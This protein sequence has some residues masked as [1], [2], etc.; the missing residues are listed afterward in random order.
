MTST[1]IAAILSNVLEVVAVYVIRLERND[2]S[3]LTR[4]AFNSHEPSPTLH[5]HFYYYIHCY[6]M[7]VAYKD[8][9]EWVSDAMRDDKLPIP[10]PDY[11]S[12]FSPGTQ[13]LTD[14]ETQ[15]PTDTETHRLTDPETHRESQTWS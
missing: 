13:R 1:Q 4:V 6:L 9:R 14:S 3:L 15:R 5:L 2:C 12:D 11:S 10:R 7:K 8:P